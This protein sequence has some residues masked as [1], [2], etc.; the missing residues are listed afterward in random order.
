MSKLYYNFLVKNWDTNGK[1][2]LIIDVDNHHAHMKV[3]HDN[4]KNTRDVRENREGLAYYSTSNNFIISTDHRHS[5]NAH[6]AT[7]VHLINIIFSLSI[8]EINLKNHQTSM[9][10][11]YWARKLLSY[12]LGVDATI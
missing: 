7:I 9:G 8:V 3:V 11:G 4:L 12:L 1:L 6:F 10:R 2:S 5:N